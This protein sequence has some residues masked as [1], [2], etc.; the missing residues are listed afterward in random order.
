[1]GKVARWV[2]VGLDLNVLGLW[3]VGDVVNLESFRCAWPFFN[4][5]DIFY[6]YYIY[7]FQERDLLF[8]IIVDNSCK[9]YVYQVP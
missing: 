1:M 4:R 3:V 5:S 7:V 8:V 2:W 6:S 9:S